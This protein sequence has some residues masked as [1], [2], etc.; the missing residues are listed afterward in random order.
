MNVA[1]IGAGKMGLPL[2]AVFASRG[3]TVTACDANRGIVDSINSGR[4]PFEE[5]GLDELVSAG[6]ANKKL[7]ATTDNRAAI[8]EAD[9]VVIIVPVMLSADKTA[10]MSVMHSVADD[11]AA[12][13]RRGSMVSFETTLPVGGTRLLGDRIARGGLKPGVDFDLV[14]SPERVK[15]QFVLRHLFDNPK[16]VGGVT[17][18]AAKRAEEFYAEFLGAP[19]TN[20]GTLESAEL[21]K[22][23]GMVYRDVNIALA[24]ELAN[25]AS[26][27]G[28]DFAAVR[29]AA[30]TDGE[31]AI[32]LPGIGVGGHCTPVYPYFLLQDARAREIDMRITELA[33]TTNEAQPSV[34]LNRL[35]DVKGAR[36]AILGVGF[37]PQVKETAYSP[38]F[39]LRD[40]LAKRGATVTVVDP[41]YSD[42]ELRALGLEP[43]QPED[44]EIIVLNTAHASFASLDFR[45]LRAGVLR[46]VLDGRDFWDPSTVKDAGVDYH[47]VMRSSS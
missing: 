17:T 20:V 42:E 12:S 13:L 6:A 15:S 21:V 8:G 10:D 9:V 32:L 44:A 35:G 27:A 26:D 23:V 25:Y 11:I 34:M 36:V 2:A 22:V 33:R 3:A 38:A 37:R 1:V 39:A 7:R 19:V 18:S 14:F 40:E 5:P 41:L 24:N 47:G 46:S 4:A 31:A 28:I 16:I 43:G 29:E 30:N 45:K